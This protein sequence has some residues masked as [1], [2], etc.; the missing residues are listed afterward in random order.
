MLQ[1]SQQNLRKATAKSVIL[2]CENL[3]KVPPR[4]RIHPL[5]QVSLLKPFSSATPESYKPDEVPGATPGGGDSVR[6]S[7]QSQQPPSSVTCSHS[8]LIPVT[9]LLITRTCI[10]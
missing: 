6:E 3:K 7:S 4:Y 5:F 9:R 2:G 1:I 8:N 10:H